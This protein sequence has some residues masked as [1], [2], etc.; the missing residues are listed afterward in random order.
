ML[1]FKVWT[2]VCWCSKCGRECVVVQ[3]E[4]GEPS[5]IPRAARA[6]L[7]QLSLFPRETDNLRFDLKFVLEQFN[8]TLLIRNSSC[9]SCS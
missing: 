1:V 9:F 3:S 5:I 2:G 4:V 6:A 7:C 8:V